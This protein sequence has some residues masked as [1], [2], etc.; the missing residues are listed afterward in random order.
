M[1]PAIAQMKV[2]GLFLDYDGTIGPLNIPR[3]E[4]AVAQETMTVL[5]RIK[6]LIPIGIITTKDLSFVVPKTPFAS[7]WCGIA[8]L[9]VKME[10]QVVED[11][12]AEAAIP[13][14]LL[15][16]K[17]TE[18]LAGGSLYIEKKCNSKGR[19]LAFC[20]DW[21]YSCDWGKAKQISMEIADICK[22]MGLWV[23]EYEQQ[24]FFD[25]YPYKTDKG[26]ALREAKLRLGIKNGMVYMG[27][28]KIDNPAFRVADV[29]IGVLHEES[30]LRLECDYYLKFENVAKFFG[31][32]LEEN[33][34]FNNNF[35]EITIDQIR[36]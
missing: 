9:E 24:P 22:S 29:G 26:K 11:P 36:R 31:H 23:I 8:G 4:S 33:L 6:Q 27:D 34:I 18:E 1:R 10:G 21:R 28:S 2:N 35:P 15:A 16:I 17:K 30:I 19:V 3:E 5:Y 12:R 7:M 14:L 13:K 32:L 25:V 20:V